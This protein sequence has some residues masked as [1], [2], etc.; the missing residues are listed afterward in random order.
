MSRL[1]LETF[2]WSQMSR[3]EGQP[4]QPLPAWIACASVQGET[5]YRKGQHH[6]QAPGGPIDRVF[7]PR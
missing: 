3:S 6:P 7:S 4:A 1:L 2:P 5:E